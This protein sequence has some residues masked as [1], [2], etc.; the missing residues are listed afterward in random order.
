METRLVEYAATTSGVKRGLRAAGLS[1]RRAALA[2][3]QSPALVSMVL[4][5][6]AKSQPCL[7][8]LAALIARTMAAREQHSAA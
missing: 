7:D 2:T 6:K 4:A 3:S 5:K 1:Q 8:K